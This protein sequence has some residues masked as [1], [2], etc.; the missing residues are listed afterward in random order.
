[1]S[2]PLA[3]DT[4]LC[5]ALNPRLMNLNLIVVR[6]VECQQPKPSKT[7]IVGEMV[8]LEVA[9]TAFRPQ[10]VHP[11]VRGEH[12]ACINKFAS[13]FLCQAFVGPCVRDATDCAA[14]CRIVKQTS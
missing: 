5:K 2:A 4:V 13:A 8:G 11:T 12:N 14:S 10:A 9:E 1:M 6:S 3:I 7:K